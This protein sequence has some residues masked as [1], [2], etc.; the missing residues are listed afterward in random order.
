MLGATG[1]AAHYPGFLP[2]PGAYA[3]EKEILRAFGLSASEFPLDGLMLFIIFLIT[4]PQQS[5]QLELQ[6]EL[7][8]LEPTANLYVMM[9][10]NGAF[11]AVF[12]TVGLIRRKRLGRA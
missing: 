2:G 1:Q 11:W 4:I 9:I 12:L 5:T 10:F 6:R 3:Q 7:I 8:S